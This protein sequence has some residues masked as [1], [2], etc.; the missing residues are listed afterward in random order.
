MP[1]NSYNK[2]V[3]FHACDD[4]NEKK[5]RNDR[6]YNGHKKTY[7]V[8]T[9]D[10]YGFLPF[11][12]I[13]GSKP[14]F[15]KFHLDIVH[16]DF[17]FIFPWAFC[18]FYILKIWQVYATNAG[19]LHNWRPFAVIFSATEQLSAMPISVRLMIRVL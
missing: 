12:P 15:Y 11:Q 5:N 6:K 13:R 3:I 16:L 9:T 10:S 17:L 14:I 7:N 18:R 1:R 8:Q 4:R 19:S 2:S